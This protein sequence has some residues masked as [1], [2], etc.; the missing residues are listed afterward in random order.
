MNTFKLIFKPTT[1]IKQVF[2]ILTFSTFGLFLNS[3]SDDDDASVSGDNINPNEEELI[4]TVRL[5]FTDT[6]NNS[7]TF[8]FTDPDGEGGNAPNIETIILEQ[9]KSYSVSAQF[10]DES[11]PNEV[12]DITVEILE[13]DDEHLV[14]FE[15]SNVDGLTIQRVDTDGSFEVGLQSSWV[16]TDSASASNGVVKLTLKHQ[17]GTKDGSCEPGDTD[18]EV[19]FPLEIN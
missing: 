18:V 8:Q 11:D 5:A 19:D 6:D 4:T 16:L 10:L 13:E 3:C 1:K 9:G 2:T 17:P 15:S 12:E 14:C 7:S